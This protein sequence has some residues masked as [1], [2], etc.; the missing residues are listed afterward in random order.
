MLEWC[1]F[2]GHIIFFCSNPK[3]NGKVLLGF[4]Q[5]T[6]VMLTYGMAYK[7]TSSQLRSMKK[8]I[9]GHFEIIGITKQPYLI[10]RS[11]SPTFYVSKCIVSVSVYNAQTGGRFLPEVNF[12]EKCM[13]LTLKYFT[14]LDQHICQDT[15]DEIERIFLIS[16]MVLP[17]HDNKFMV[18][19]EKQELFH[20]FC[21]HW[22]MFAQW[23]WL[24]CHL[25]QATRSTLQY[26]STINTEVLWFQF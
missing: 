26:H 3:T 16:P 4:C 8:T 15:D 11:C 12:C 1:N 23:G 14:K 2:V 18:R 10:N 22:V 19:K 6:T 5:G 24:L 20:I 7:I 9:F 13:Q 25:Q 21:I 17:W